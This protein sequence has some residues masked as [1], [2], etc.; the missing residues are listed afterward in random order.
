M[1]TGHQRT[2]L[3]LTVLSSISAVR[4]AKQCFF[5][6]G[7][8]GDWTPCNE[9]QEHSACCAPEDACLSNNYCFQQ[10]P[11]PDQYSLRI[12]RG[13][14]TD[15]SWESPNCP[16]YCSDGKHMQSH[17]TSRASLTHD[18]LVLPGYTLTVLLVKDN[19]QGEF[20]CSHPFNYSTQRCGFSTKG[21]RPVSSTEPFT[22]APGQII[23]DRKTG[24]TINANTT[25]SEAT[26]LTTTTVAASSSGKSR[27]TDNNNVAIGVGVAV[28]LAILFLAACAAVILLTTKLKRLERQHQEALQQQHLLP[29]T[30]E[31]QNADLIGRHQ[32]KQ[33]VHGHQGVW[34]SSPP[35]EAPAENRRFELGT[36]ATA[37]EAPNS[38]VVHR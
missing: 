31:I 29:Q 36:E 27:K 16:D 5:P 12:S 26:L 38:P 30:S 18:P 34:H 1:S 11:A 20:C 9:Q 28:P 21:P 7:T 37:I 6:N 17:A 2:F 10:R 3:L 8:A 35:H 32:M 4:A 13:M 23:F 19:L 15:Q 24:A 25:S 22:L 14:C 33:A